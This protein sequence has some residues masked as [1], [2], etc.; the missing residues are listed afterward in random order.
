MRGAGPKSIGWDP[1]S[2]AL[3]LHPYTVKLEWCM[4]TFPWEGFILAALGQNFAVQIDKKK[5]KKKA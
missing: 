1:K 3:H 5:K 4:V 2:V